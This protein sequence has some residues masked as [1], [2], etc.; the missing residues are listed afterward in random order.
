[1]HYSPVSFER[2]SKYTVGLHEYARAGD[3]ME[4]V[5]GLAERSGQGVRSNQYVLW[6]L[7]Q[8][9]LICSAFSAL[10]I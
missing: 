2:F 1:M 3:V 7:Q 4:C 10:L 6:V 8:G 5:N 9:Y